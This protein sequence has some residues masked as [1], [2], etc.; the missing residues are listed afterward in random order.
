M[1]ETLGDDV[2][3]AIEESN[4][5]F[6][7]AIAARDLAGITD[8]YTGDAVLLLDGA[9]EQRG[10]EAIQNFFRAAINAGLQS[11]EF[12]TR[13]VHTLGDIAIER[14]VY[15][16]T[17]AG[18]APPETGRYVVVHQRGDDGAWRALYDVTQRLSTK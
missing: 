5:A 10:R 15:A 8:A 4:T 1:N 13:D 6:S 14:G 3:H 2:R 7:A 16:M 9:P 12:S 17:S 18:D 11:L